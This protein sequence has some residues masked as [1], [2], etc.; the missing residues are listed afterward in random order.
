MED[1]EREGSGGKGREW[2]GKRGVEC[3]AH[4]QASAR[5]L[6]L[7]KD[8]PVAWAIEHL[9]ESAP[10]LENAYLAGG[11]GAKFHLYRGNASPLPAIK[12]FLDH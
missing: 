2:K 3:G 4:K 5:G 10:L 9:W 12:P 1:R 6:A 7:A 11:S 8:G